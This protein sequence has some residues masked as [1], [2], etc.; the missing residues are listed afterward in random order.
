LDLGAVSKSAR[1]SADIAKIQTISGKLSTAVPNRKVDEPTLAVGGTLRSPFDLVTLPPEA[2]DSRQAAA[3]SATLDGL[4]VT[5]NCSADTVETAYN[6]PSVDAITG[7]TLIRTDSKP[8]MGQAGGGVMTF[9]SKSGANDVHGS[10]SDFLRNDALDARGFFAP[11][12]SVY[13]QNDFGAR[14]GDPIYIPKLYYGRN[15]AFFFISYK[16]F[17]N[18]VGNNGRIFSVPTPEMQGDFSKWVNAGGGHLT[19][20]D[21]AS[22]RANAAGPARYATR[23]PVIRFRR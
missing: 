20:Y 8:N 3:S 22:S 18:R 21:P 11:T 4:S 15:R 7:L 14:L 16:G 2:H 9:P 23:S 12:R 13:K 1:V 17:R 5:T 19:I 6:A 10:A